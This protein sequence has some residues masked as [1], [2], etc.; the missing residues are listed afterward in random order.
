MTSTKSQPEFATERQISF[1]EKNGLEIDASTPYQ[2]AFDMI[3]AHIAASPRS[4]EERE[5]RNA[6]R[7]ER[8]ASLPA[9]GKQ[10]ALISKI[11]KGKFIPTNQLQVRGFFAGRRNRR[12]AP[13]E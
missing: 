13:A 4:A 8:L 11:T 3:G 10:V 5:A 6:A 1:A 2:V 7:R 12:P 9:T